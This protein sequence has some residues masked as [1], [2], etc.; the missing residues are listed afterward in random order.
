MPIL[1]GF[2]RALLVAFFRVLTHYRVLGLENVPQQGPLLVVANHLS[3]ADPPLL[4]VSLGRPVTFMAKRE[5]FRFPVIGYVLKRFGAFPVNRGR[6]DL[7]AMRW[8]YRLLGDGNALVMF[9]EGMRSPTGRLRTAFRGAAQI[10]V[11]ADVPI[12]PVAISGTEMLERPFGLLRRPEVTVNIGRPFSLPRSNGRVS[13][14]ELEELTRLIMAGVAD[15][16]PPAY[17]GDYDRNN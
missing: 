9:P 7:V 8:T 4:G 13:R 16:L 12:L 3:L 11:R 5:L 17:R 2:I 15:L 6:L 14:Q 1:R 10:A